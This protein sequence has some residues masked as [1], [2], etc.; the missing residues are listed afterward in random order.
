M[1]EIVDFHIPSCDE[2]RK[3]YEAYNQKEMR[4]R[5]YFDAVMRVTQTW[6]D[7]SGMIIQMSILVRGWNYLFANFGFDE[8][9]NC[10]R[11]NLRNLN[12]FRYRDI[13]TLAD[14]DIERIEDLSGEFLNALRRT[15]DNRRSAVSVAKALH[16]L[17]PNFFPL[18]DQYI[19]GDYGCL[20]VADIAASVYATFC[21]KMKIMADR[22]RHCVPTPD[23]R[24]LLK[25]IDEY[26]Y[27]KYT[28]GWI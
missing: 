25:R 7:P 20:Y 28:M 16:R 27:S 3:G 15:A 23:D 19:A 4:G 2:S 26:N 9:E 22:V 14:T 18:W 24:S 12:E 17:A 5:I 6:G 10:I 13:D 11:R 8:L 1:D 21:K